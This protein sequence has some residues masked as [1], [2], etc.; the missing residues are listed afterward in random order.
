MAAACS[1][2][3]RRLRTLT[4]QLS[5]LSIRSININVRLYS[6]DDPKSEV[7]FNSEEDDLQE[8]RRTLK[9]Q[10]KAIKFE[11]MKREM[12]P[13]GPLERT[14]TW[15]AIEQ[16]RYLKQEFPE[17]W[18]VPQLAEGFNVSPDV[19][20]R[21]LRSKFSVPEKRKVKQDLK[22]SKLL[23]YV[24]QTPKKGAL[25]LAPGAKYPTQQVLPSGVN[26][27]Q[28][29]L[30]LIPPAEKIQ[31][32]ALTVRIKDALTH[33]N[34]GNMQ[35]STQM[36]Q[37]NMPGVVPVQSQTQVTLNEDSGADPAPS[38]E[39]EQGMLDEEWDGEVLN[40]AEL[41]ELAKSGVK[42]QMQV[43]QKG[44][45]FFDGDGNFLYRI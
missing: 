16:I 39:G 35:P 10:Q 6:S 36:A 4:T 33:G 19:I 24:S 38:F 42:N 9:R 8:I 13:R 12:E 7:S 3:L 28:A 45:E 37:D 30:R 5:V 27:E 21:V 20:R 2:C 32:N 26:E 14:L 15:N 22:V 44:K 34:K 40:D 31:S 41:E 29:A 18:T 11:R 43:I 17:E 1:A 23:G 25:Q